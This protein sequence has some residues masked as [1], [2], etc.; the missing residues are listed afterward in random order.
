MLL[1]MA[2]HVG[3]HRVA[4]ASAQATFWPFSAKTRA[5]KIPSPPKNL[6]ITQRY[7]AE[8]FS[9]LHIVAL[10]SPGHFSLEDFGAERRQVCAET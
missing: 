6:T 1:C 7:R 4:Q 5:D 10:P 3:W 2:E 9:G 8:P